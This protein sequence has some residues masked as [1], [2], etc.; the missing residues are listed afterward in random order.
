MVSNTTVASSSAENELRTLTSGRLINSAD[1]PMPVRLSVMKKLALAPTMMFA[2][3]FEWLL[4]AFPPACVFNPLATPLKVASSLR[5]KLEEVV[6]LKIP[7]DWSTSRVA[8]LPIRTN[9][10]L[11]VNHIKR[12]SEVVR[13]LLDVMVA[14][15]CNSTLCD[16]RILA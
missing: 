13:S 4:E 10:L 5:M 15:S 7:P 9:E 8:P 6:T 2:N 3:E 11:A 14:L 12:E 16:T 1:V